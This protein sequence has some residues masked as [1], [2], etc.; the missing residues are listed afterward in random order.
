MGLFVY[1]VESLSR[2]VTFTTEDWNLLS[3]ISVLY[4]PQFTGIFLDASPT[5]IATVKNAVINQENSSSDFIIQRS[6][7]DL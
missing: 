4:W 3:N 5:I 7:G 1:P 2:S 6:A